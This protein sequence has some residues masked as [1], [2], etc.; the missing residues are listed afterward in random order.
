[1]ERLCITNPLLI[2]HHFQPQEHIHIYTHTSQNERETFLIIPE[3]TGFQ[4]AGEKGKK[5]TNYWIL[6]QNEIKFE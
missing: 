1:M 2:P 4:K 5:S 6:Q 3:K